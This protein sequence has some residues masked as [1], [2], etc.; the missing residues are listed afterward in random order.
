MEYFGT[1]LTEY[2][3]YRWLLTEKGLEK[4]WNKFDELPFSPESL[5]NKLSKGQTAFYQG[6]SYTVLAIAGSPKDTRPGTKSVF[7]IKLKLDKTAMIEMI[8][9]NKTAMSIINEMPFEVEW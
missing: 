5:T 1:N 8:K 3:H 2:G 7:W 9:D 4:Q 6:G